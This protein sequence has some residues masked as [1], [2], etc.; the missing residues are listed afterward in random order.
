MNTALR[1]PALLLSL[2]LAACATTPGRDLD[3]EDLLHQLRRLEED[4]RLQNHLQPEA[5]ERARQAIESMSSATRS[6]IKAQRR[7]L[8][9]KLIEIA[10]FQAQRHWAEQ[11]QRELERTLAQLQIDIKAAEAELAR[12]EAEQALLLSRASLEEAERARK[13]ALRARQER[14]RA[15]R[16]A[17]LARQQAEAARRVAEASE[18]EAQLA[19]QEAELT[20][21][22]MK[23]LQ[24]QLATFQA[25]ETARGLVV[26]LG[27]ISFASGQARL[28]TE[29]AGEIGK[30]VQFLQQ[31][32]RH[33]IRVEGHTDNRGS[34]EFNRKLSLQRAESVARALAEAGVN[35]QRIET[36][37]YGEERPIASNQTAE[38]RSANRRVE[39]VLIKPEHP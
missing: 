36:V 39:V 35:R 12:R 24:A 5:L 34:A 33:R 16:E 15:A 31:Y 13:D 1:L 27:D 19:R 11:R 23:D 14:D 17:E 21:Q 22:A 30:L 32:P 2:L 10:R 6:N 7:Y 9:D 8:A 4:P 29:T 38:G 20:A 18:R 37:G 25:R 3:R 26:T 28:K